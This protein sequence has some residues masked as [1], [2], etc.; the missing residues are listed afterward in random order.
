MI[1]M[2]QMKL[3]QAIEELRQPILD[4]EAGKRMDIVIPPLQRTPQW[5][6]YQHALIERYG[7][8]VYRIAHMTIHKELLLEQPKDYVVER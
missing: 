8:K 7:E 6:R 3:E 2:E 5:E 4:I 1:K